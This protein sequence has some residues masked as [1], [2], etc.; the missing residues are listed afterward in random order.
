M[1]GELT[2]CFDYYYLVLVHPHILREAHLYLEHFFVG[3]GRRRA[4]IR[5]HQMLKMIES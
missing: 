4:A 5:F 3:N 1:H 2:G